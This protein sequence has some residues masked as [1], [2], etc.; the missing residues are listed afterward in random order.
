VNNAP[1]VRETALTSAYQPGEDKFH[2]LHPKIDW[3]IQLDYAQE[4]GL[5]TRSYRLVEIE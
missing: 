2:A 3:Q 4:I 1:G 5:G